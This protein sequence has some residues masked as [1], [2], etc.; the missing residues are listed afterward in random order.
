MHFQGRSKQLQ[1]WWRERERGRE[2][3]RERERESIWVCL[4]EVWSQNVHQF[5]GV[6]PCLCSEN[7]SLFGCVHVSVSVCMCVLG[8]MFFVCVCV[9]VCVCVHMGVR[10]T[11]EQFLILLCACVNGG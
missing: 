11:V 2:R 4:H 6:L 9:C 10:K 1:S 7:D 5:S 3:E 8:R